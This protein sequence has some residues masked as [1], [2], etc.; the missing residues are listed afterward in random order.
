MLQFI[1]LLGIALKIWEHREKT[2]YLVSYLDLKKKYYEESNRETPDNCVLDNI[3]FEL[4]LLS[5]SFATEVD[6][7]NPA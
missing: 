7:K 5:S 2:K 6:R 1:E 3:E 4:Y